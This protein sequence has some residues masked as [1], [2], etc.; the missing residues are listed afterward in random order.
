MATAAKDLQ[1][2]DISNS[3]VD[4]NAITAGYLPVNVRSLF[5][6]ASLPCDLYS[7][8]RRGSQQAIEMVRLIQKN[9]LYDPRLQHYFT[10]NDIEILY[11]KVEDESSFID[12]YNI[13]TKEILANKSIPPEKKAELLFDQAEYIFKKVYRE[14]PTPEN[15]ALGQQ[16]VSQISLHALGNNGTM[17]ALVSLFS[18]DYYTFTHSIQVSILGMAFCRFLGLER[19]EI[20][21]FGMGALFHDIGKNSIDERILNK[22][23]KLDREEFDVI[24]THPILGYEQIQ[25]TGIV[26]EP[27]LT[28][29]L[30][31]HEAMDGSGYPHGLSHDRIHP[32]ARIARI[33]DIYDA[34]TTK[35]VYKDALSPLDAL[36]LM[37]NEMKKTLDLNFFENFI[38][39][40]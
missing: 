40:I 9:H 27:Q 2:V 33:I 8:L 18:K 23:G 16:F 26:T 3:D 36:F 21:D 34:L 25:A 15:V 38:K 32:Y 4:F 35:R 13:N 11:I 29:V 24:K 39:F 14:K 19:K 31:H 7:L 6:G 30:H 17:K 37:K 28:M 1:F 20:E 5:P 12:Y 10:K 22:P